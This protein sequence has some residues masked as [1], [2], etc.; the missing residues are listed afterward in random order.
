M[1]CA[2]L[3]QLKC[4]NSDGNVHQAGPS[5][6]GGR[7]TIP[8]TPPDFGRSKTFPKK[9]LRIIMSLR[10]IRPFTSLSGKICESSPYF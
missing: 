7:G 8:D 4:N 5:E 3:S 9:D 1:Q 2:I 6:L 10:I